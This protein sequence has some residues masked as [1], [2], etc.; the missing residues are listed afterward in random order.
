M[1]WFVRPSRSQ[2]RKE[3]IMKVKLKIFIIEL[4]NAIFS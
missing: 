1:N 4:E 3:D 2:M